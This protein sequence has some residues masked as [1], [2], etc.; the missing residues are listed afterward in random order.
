MNSNSLVFSHV[1]HIL[2]TISGRSNLQAQITM[3]HSNLGV[4]F[5]NFVFWN[6]E[7]NLSLSSIRSSLVSHVFMAMSCTSSSA[8][9]PN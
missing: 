5:Q 4:L 7:S 2:V 9:N 8:E 1:R 6:L 3:L